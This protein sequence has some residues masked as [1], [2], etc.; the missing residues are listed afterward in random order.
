VALRYCSRRA[1]R[2]SIRLFAAAAAFFLAAAAP[3]PAL[4][5]GLA[6]PSTWDEEVFQG[7]TRYV[8]ERA[9]DGQNALLAVSEGTASGLVRRVAIDLRKTPYLNWSWRIDR[10]PGG[11]NER[12]PEGDDYAARVYVVDSGG[13]FFWRTVAL[14]YVWS[15]SQEAGVAWPN[16]YTGNVHM[17]AV[18]GAGSPLGVWRTHKRN[19]RDDFRNYLQRE[20]ELIGAGAVMTDTDNAGGFASAWYGKIYFSAE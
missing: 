17:I 18:D 11:L 16:A 6:D 15:G 14:N 10:A 7:R 20:V 12:A 5:P 2:A 9:D 1:L 4:A 8:L 13:A 3:L 19:V